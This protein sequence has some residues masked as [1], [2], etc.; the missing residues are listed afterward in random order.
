MAGDGVN[1]A[2]AIARASVGVAMRGGAEASLSAADVYL[3]RPG[4]GPLLDLVGGAARTM[5]VIRRTIAVSLAYNVV[6][7]GLAV[8]GVIDPLIAAILMPVS[9][10]TVVL[11]SW[12]SRT[13][14]ATT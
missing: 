13:F 14:E 3:A 12:R 6:G 2:A 9:S 7:A 4:L 1:D 8:T 5:R 11:I 10:V